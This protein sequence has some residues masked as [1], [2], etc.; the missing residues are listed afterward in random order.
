MGGSS[1]GGGFWWRPEKN[2]DDGGEPFNK[3][4]LFMAGAASLP[5][6]LWEKYNEALD[7]QPLPTKA[8]T[9]LTGFTIGDVLAQNF[10]G[11]KGSKFD[12]ARLTR[13][14]FHVIYQN[15]CEA[16][17]WPLLIRTDPSSFDWGGL[18]YFRYQ[19]SI[20]APLG[21]VI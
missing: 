16:V 4:M 1:G 14:V 8:A 12:Y 2:N 5:A 19:S 15:C 20:L 11:T 17:G 10:L 6:L 7:S 3:E 21:D 13:Y 9:S 18:R